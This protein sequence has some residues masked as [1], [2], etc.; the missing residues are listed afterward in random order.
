MKNLKTNKILLSIIFIIIVISIIW[1]IRKANEG[2]DKYWDDQVEQSTQTFPMEGNIEDLV[3]FSINPGQEVSG[4]MSVDGIIKGA[5]FF[6]ANI[7][8]SI[9]DA[10][11][12][13]T[14]Y[15]P[16]YANATTDWM[17]TGPVS[18]S[19]DIDFSIMPKGKYYIKITQDD[20]SGGESGKPIKFVTIPIIVK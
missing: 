13:A 3:S 8:V 11:K 16:G 4:K 10:N 6:E 1:Y 14:S 7:L 20:P 2:K 12:N 17:T 18:F 19:L 5:Y 9:L 15:G